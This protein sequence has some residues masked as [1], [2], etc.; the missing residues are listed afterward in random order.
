MSEPAATP[1]RRDGPH[2]RSGGSA[3]APGVDTAPRERAT[4]AAG[5][6]PAPAVRRGSLWSDAWRELRTN[7]M[8]LFAAAVIV[9]FGTMAAWPELFTSVDPTVGDLSRSLERPSTEHWFGLDLQGR[10]YYARV[11]HGARISLIVGIAVSLGATALALLLGSLAGYYGGALDAVLSRVTDTFFAIPLVL[12]GLVFIS[13]LSQARA[14]AFDESGLWRVVIVLV[15]FGWP[16]MMRI[17]RSAVIGEKEQEYVAAARALG[18]GDLRILVRHI[19]PNSLAPVIVYATIT[20]GVV[21]TVEATLSFLG[22][23][24]E[25]PAISWGLMVNAAQTRVLQAPHLLFFPGLFLSLTVFGFIL[26]GDALRDAL[27]PKLR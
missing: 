1:R 12:A 3:D 9:L 6:E 2:E 10:D 24:L 8:F 11:V 20:T 27:D 23:G 14:L 25:P 4:V 19:L 7:P 16:T 13:A 5:T 22:V 18:A 17:A 21:I 26:M 15:L